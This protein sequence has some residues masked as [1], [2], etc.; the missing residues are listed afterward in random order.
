VKVA[1]KVPDIGIEEAE[2]IEILINPNDTVKINQGLIIVEGQKASI[3]IPCLYNGIIKTIEVK[4]GDVIKMNS[5]IAFLEILDPT[6]KQD[7]KNVLLKEKSSES[8]NAI[9]KNSFEKKHDKKISSI[10]IHSSPSVKRLCRKLNISISKIHG[11]GRKNRVLQEDVKNYFYNLKKSQ[12]FVDIFEKSSLKSSNKL[13]VHLN[14]EEEEIIYLSKIRQLS[15]SNLTKNWKRVPHVTQFD[16]VDITKLEKFRKKI[17]ENFENK[18]INL[19]LLPFIIKS[20]SINLIKFRK[21]NS[22]LHIK[23]DR[24]ILKKD[25]NIGIAVNTDQGIIVPVLKNVNQKTILEISNE[26]VELSKKSQANKLL[27]NE[28]NDGCFT[29]SNLGGFGGMEFTPIINCPEVAILGVSRA[30]IEAVW[31]KNKF[32]PRLLLPVSLSYDHRVIDGVDG[33][34]FIKNFGENLSNFYKILF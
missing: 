5:I 16:K 25:I 20:I 13:D 21:F 4:V 34:I 32:V 29:I 2:V 8:K 18:N 15:G 30:K 3:E 9:N 26:L 27:M 31:K 23:K 28:M 12:N 19:T 33:A 22:V 24:I 11:T 7:V 6:S 10:L 1:L 14:N 17:N